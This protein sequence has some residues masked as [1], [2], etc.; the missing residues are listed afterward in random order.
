[1]RSPAVIVAAN[2]SALKIEEIKRSKNEQICPPLSFTK[3][4][5]ITSRIES[6]VS[7][8]FVC[9]KIGD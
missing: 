9:G 6:G 4:P 3:L 1:M 5:S 8:V 7:I 2:D